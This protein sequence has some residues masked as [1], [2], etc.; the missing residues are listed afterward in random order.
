MAGREDPAGATPG[1]LPMALPAKFDLVINL[2]TARA[3]DFT[4][5]PALLLRADR[6]MECGSPAVDETGDPP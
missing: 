2:A 5:P 1:D 6:V 4:I 3:L